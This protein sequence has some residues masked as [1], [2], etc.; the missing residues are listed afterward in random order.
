MYIFNEIHLLQFSGYFTSEERFQC[1]CGAALFQVL[2]MEWFCR[3]GNVLLLKHLAWT[4]VMKNLA[5]GQYLSLSDTIHVLYLCVY[6]CIHTNAKELKS[7]VYLQHWNYCAIYFQTC[8]CSSTALFL[9]FVN[10]VFTSHLGRYNIV[11]LSVLLSWN[12]VFYTLRQK[13]VRAEPLRYTLVP[14]WT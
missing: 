8:F 3:H 7:S 2:L 11:T 9:T 6:M 5:L 12:P 14:E 1:G 13:C 10:P 4:L